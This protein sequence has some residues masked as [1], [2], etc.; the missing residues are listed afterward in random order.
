MQYTY[1]VPSAYRSPI[2]RPCAQFI[3]FVCHDVQDD[4]QTEINLQHMYCASP[5]LSKRFLPSHT[6]TSD[7]DAMKLLVGPHQ[8]FRCSSKTYRTSAS[9][10]GGCSRLAADVICTRLKGTSCLLPESSHYIFLI[11]SKPL[12]WAFMA[13]CYNEVPRCCASP[14]A[15]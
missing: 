4:L 11:V 5:I 2:Q 3:A 7:T 14:K 10:K 9:S 15:Q 1:D 13:K 8:S 12:S 6:T